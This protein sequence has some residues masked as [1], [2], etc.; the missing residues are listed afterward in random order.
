MDTQNYDDSGGICCRP[1][2]G[3]GLD[4]GR[5]ESRATRTSSPTAAIIDARP[6]DARP[7]RP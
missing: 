4:R 1:D 6:I 7:N 5:S 3:D 2:V